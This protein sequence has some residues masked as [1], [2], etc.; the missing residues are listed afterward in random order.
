MVKAALVVDRRFY[1]QSDCVYSEGPVGPETGGRYLRWFDEVV[2]LGRC[3]ESD[4]VDINKLNLVSENG[5]KFEF[6]PNISGVKE[7]ISNI[8][9]ARKKIS[10]I[11]DSCDCVICRLPTELG[12]EAAKIASR[13]NKCYVLEIGGCIY[14]GYRTHGSLK[15]IF[16]A[17]FAYMNMRKIVSSSKWVSY[18]T[19]EFLQKRYPANRFA[20]TLSAP[21]VNLPFISKDVLNKKLE[22][23]K[24]NECLT[25]GTIGSLVGGFKGIDVAIK[26]LKLASP[27]IP[28]FRYRILGGGD[29]NNLKQLAIKNN[30][31]SSIEFDG[32]LPAGDPVFEWLGGIDIYLQPS[33]R[34]GVPRAL[35]E[36][37]SQ[38]CPVLASNVAGIPELLDTRYLHNP[39]DYKKLAQQIVEITK[40]ENRLRCAS[41]NWI[42]AHDYL[43]MSLEAKRDFFWCGVRD[44]VLLK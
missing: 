18:V 44:F 27:H 34:E 22:T 20:T 6:L 40:N 1:K 3:L 41:R 10:E 14:D 35:I 28:K 36:A 21:N 32:T 8:E 11:I 31:E 30:L 15:G 9:A 5:L 24:N 2:V 37:M 43:L 4:L 25:F 26:A 39:G 19:Q 17:P 16:Y 12:L 42:K 23:T 33:R 13:K 29:G 7:R 38:A